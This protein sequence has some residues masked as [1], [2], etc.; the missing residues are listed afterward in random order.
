MR[1][2]LLVS[3][4]AL[5]AWLGAAATLVYA[6]LRANREMAIVFRFICASV[7]V[8]RASPLARDREV[9]HRFERILAEVGKSCPVNEGR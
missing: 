3:A 5:V 1:S 6:D 9:A 7:E 4:C 2:F 8:R